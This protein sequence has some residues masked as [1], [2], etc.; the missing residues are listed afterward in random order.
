MLE[1]VIV[2]LF[3]AVVFI[4]MIFVAGLYKT[5]LATAHEA[6]F[7]NMMN[8][9]NDC[10]PEGPSIAHLAMEAPPEDETSKLEESVRKLID[11]QRFIVEGGGL[12]RV[13]ARHEFTLGNR[14]PNDPNRPPPLS[15]TVSWR[16]TTACNPAVVSFSPLDLL[17]KIGLKEKLTSVM[18]EGF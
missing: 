2:A 15:G 10:T 5:K 9:T 14:D 11:I 1:A 3:L 4:G 18:S 6:R 16:S 7:R 12:S 13:E 17:D 8:A